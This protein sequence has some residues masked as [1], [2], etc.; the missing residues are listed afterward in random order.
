MAV[1]CGGS[2]VAAALSTARGALDD[3]R[4]VGTDVSDLSSLAGE[5][6]GTVGATQ[7]TQ[8]CTTEPQP[9]EIR[10]ARGEYHLPQTG[11]ALRPLPRGFEGAPTAPVAAAAALADAPAALA[12]AS[13]VRAASSADRPTAGASAP[14][15]GA[16]S[17]AASAALGSRGG[18]FHLSGGRPPSLSSSSSSSDE[19]FSRVVGGESPLLLTQLVL[20]ALLLPALPAPDPLLLPARSPLPLLSL[21]GVGDRS[22]LGRGRVRLRD[23]HHHPLLKRQLSRPH[24][25]VARE[26]GREEGLLTTEASGA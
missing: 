20:L 25:C 2:L 15:A 14:A 26:R 6:A 11:E 23:V 12:G 10:G 24:G 19:E 22:G 13:T 1:P 21:H 18:G 7:R 5:R 4:L 3:C 16:C 9:L 17:S 8:K